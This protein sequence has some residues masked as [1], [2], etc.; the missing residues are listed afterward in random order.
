M[1]FL[2]MKTYL[3]LF[4]FIFSLTTFAQKPNPDF[5]IEKVKSKFTEVKDYQVDVKIEVDVDFLKVPVT[6]AKIFF[7]Q[8]DKIKFNSDGFALLPKEG[9]NFSPLTVLQG[10]YTSI[11]EK[12]EELNGI[13]VYVIKIIPLG[14]SKEVIL[15]TLWIDKKDFIIRKVESTTKMNGTFTIDLKYDS[16]NIKYSLPSSLIFSFDISRTNIPKGLTGSHTEEEEKPKR[17]KDKPKIAKGLVTITYTN[18]I[19]NKGIS[20]SIFEE[21]KKK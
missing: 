3:L 7:K 12:E 19:I 9:L 2:I 6:E 14:G 10:D 8:P 13:K 17:G 1:K 4:S 5:I 20:D 15:S 21:S 11:F 16:K 18:Y